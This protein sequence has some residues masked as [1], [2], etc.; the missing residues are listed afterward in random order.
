MQSIYVKF[1]KIINLAELLSFIKKISLLISIFVMGI[2][3]TNA[4]VKIVCFEYETA[5]LIKKKIPK[6]IK[7]FSLLVNK[8]S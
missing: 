1:F 7:I 6:L 2:L 8:S 3:F 4:T 5:K